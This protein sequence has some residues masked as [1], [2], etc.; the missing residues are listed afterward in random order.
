MSI[1]DI[2]EHQIWLTRKGGYRAHR[3]T[4][5]F[6]KEHVYAAASLTSASWFD[7]ETCVGFVQSVS[8]SGVENFGHKSIDVGSPD[9]VGLGAYEV[10]ILRRD[11]VTSLTFELAG[12]GGAAA[13]FMFF[14]LDPGEGRGGETKR[15]AGSDTSPQSHDTLLGFDR[16]TNEL[17]LV[18]EIHGDEK[19]IAT[20][21]EKWSGGGRDKK[22]DVVLVATG[23][24]FRYDPDRNYV[25]DKHGQVRVEK[26]KPRATK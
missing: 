24:G 25:L 2:R 20:E 6:D 19:F 10:G 14:I 4:R 15:D 16:N 22:N 21:I 9:R 23:K 5:Q 17:S 13:Q 1:I 26:D 11:H 7:V 3:V 12:D 18:H 8:D